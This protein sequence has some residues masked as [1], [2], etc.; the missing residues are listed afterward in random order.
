M[1]GKFLICVDNK[2]Y[3]ASLEIRKLYDMIPDQDAQQHNQVIII[4]EK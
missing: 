4:D 2:G 1:K 3:E